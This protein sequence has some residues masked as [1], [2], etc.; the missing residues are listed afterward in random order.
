LIQEKTMSSMSTMSTMSTMSSKSRSLLVGAGVASLLAAGG[1]ATAGTTIDVPGD[2]PT[3]QS[4]IDAAVGGDVVLVAPGVY[5]ESIDFL[6]KAIVVRSSDGA[7]ATTIDGTGAKASVVTAVSGE[8]PDTI[9]EGFTITNGIVGTV[10]EP[11]PFYTFGGGMYVDQSSPTIVDCIVTENQSGFGGGAYFRES[12]SEVSGTVFHDN[13]ANTDGGGAQCW[14]GGVLFTGCTFTL[15]RAP[16]SF[17][18][19]VHFTRGTPVVVDCVFANN[20]AATGG[21][22]TWNSFGD[23]MVVTGC[24]VTSNVAVTGGGI[25]VRPG[26]SDLALSN[27]EICG[28]FPD[29]ISGQYEDIGKNVLCTGCQG[30]IN[31]DGDVNGSDISIMIGYWGF[32]PIG[33][34]V[35]ADLNNSGVVDA[36]DLSIL[37]ANWGVCP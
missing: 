33:V 28:N 35:S 36:A 4:A 3:I 1:I 12:F 9:L 27:T 15:N 10:Y 34:P 17:G 8:G 31:N 26:F 6:G 13:Y 37:L 24:S 21:G 22:F 5:T 32:S 29:A 20:T 16:Q 11:L 2:Y 19:G 23:G 18:G 7:A 14:G 30:D 25:W